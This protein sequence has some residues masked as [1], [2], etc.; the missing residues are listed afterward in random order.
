MLRTCGTK[1]GLNTLSPGVDWNCVK[2]YH[3]FLF[4][5]KFH[6]MQFRGYENMLENVSRG[7]DWEHIMS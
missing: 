3:L 4:A 6:E 2:F 7:D 5:Q 1:Q